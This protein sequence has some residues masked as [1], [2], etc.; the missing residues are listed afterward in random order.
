MS[1]TLPRIL[2][3]MEADAKAI[4]DCFTIFFSRYAPQFP[5]VEGEIAPNDCYAQ[6][7]YLFWVIVTIGSRRY[8]GDPTLLSQLAPHILDLTKHAA[9]SREAT[10]YTIQGFM[11]MCT[12]PLPYS[13]MSKDITHILS[14]VLLQ[15]TLSV[16]LHI[17]GMGQDFSRIKLQ[18]DRAQMYLRA[19]LWVLC[20]VV[21]QRISYTEGM[22]PV[23]IPDNYDHD[24]QQAQSIYALP[25]ALRFQKTLSRILTE[26]ILEL[27]RYALSK[28]MQQRAAVLNPII[29]AASV[30]LSQLEPECPTEIDRYYLICAELQI[31]AFHLLGPKESFDNAKLAKMH[32]LACNA[33]E[34]LNGLDRAQSWAEYAPSTA[35]KYL[36]LAGFT[37]LKLSRCHVRDS[38]DLERGKSAYFTA[39]SLFRKSAVDS[40]ALFGRSAKILTQLWTSKQIFKKADGTTDALTLRCGSRLAM[41]IAYDCYWWWR[42]EFAGLPNPY[43]DKG[44]AMLSPA[45]RILMDTDDPVEHLTPETFQNM[46]WL[47]ESFP[48]FAW[49]TMQDLVS[50][51]WPPH[52]LLRIRQH[53]LTLAQ[54]GCNLPQT[55]PPG[56]I[57]TISETLSV[58]LSLIAIE[59]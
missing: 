35:L 59:M 22:P 11:L 28:V 23:Y 56:G 43:E 27:E 45:C 36:T 50:M 41:S 10:L 25:P 40:E 49:P 13:S 6:S 53:L 20:I 21:C 55:Q 2:G 32:D 34:T 29:D 3:D 12:W 37:L 5:A 52:Q 44:T 38:L 42:S 26:S 58:Q 24:S 8:H 51:D 46:A 15:H 47:Q 19:R 30:S 18:E 48:E 1:P 39:I 9:F 33:V 17:F 14:G 57:A 54:Y 7:P 16:G 31:M 4:D